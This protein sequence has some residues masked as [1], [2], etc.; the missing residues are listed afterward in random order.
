[1]HGGFFCNQW[2]FADNRADAV[3]RLL[4]WPDT[5]PRKE[6]DKSL[7]NTSLIIAVLARHSSHGGDKHSSVVDCGIL[8]RKIINM[9]KKIYQRAIIDFKRNLPIC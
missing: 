8:M 6:M 4:I 5:H 1:M 2:A 9:L 7:G 3:D